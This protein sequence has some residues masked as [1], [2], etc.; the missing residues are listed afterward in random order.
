MGRAWSSISFLSSSPSTPQTDGKD[1]L[2]L[3]E[4]GD[5]LLAREK[6]ADSA[7][8]V[9][10]EFVVARDIQR[11]QRGQFPTKRVTSLPPWTSCELLLRHEGALHVASIGANGLQFVPFEERVVSKIPHIHDR[12]AIRRL[13][14]D[15]RSENLSITLRELAIQIAA[16]APISWQ[17]LLF[18]TTRTQIS[19]RSPRQ[20]SVDRD[21]VIDALKELPPIIRRLL[22]RMLELFC[23]GLTLDDTSHPHNPDKTEDPNVGTELRVALDALGGAEVTARLSAAFVATVYEFVHLLDPINVSTNNPLVPAAFWSNC[24]DNERLYFTPSTALGSEMSLVI[25]TRD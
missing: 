5:L 1:V 12:F 13:R 4:D 14:H 2:A 7:L 23:Q 3:C 16:I 20:Q 21:A 25:P 11:M 24:S 8:R 19:P 6:L 10:V 18:P 15:A 17:T 9:G 22:R